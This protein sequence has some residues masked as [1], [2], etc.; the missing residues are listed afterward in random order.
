MDLEKLRASR[1]LAGC[2][3]HRIESLNMADLQHAAVS[4]RPVDQL[5]SFF[6]I[7]SDWL[8]NENIDAVVEQ[9]N[10][11]S[12]V[13]DSGNG[14]SRSIHFAQ[15]FTIIRKRRGLVQR[16]NFLGAGP[17]YVDNTGKLDVR[18]LGVEP[19]VLLSDI[20]NTDDGDLHL[21]HRD[22][23]NSRGIRLAYQFLPIDHQRFSGLDRQRRDLQTLHQPDS[24][25]TDNRNIEAQV[26]VGFC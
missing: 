9:I 11:N 4:P 7:R 25:G 12:A 19:R 23:C 14:Q 24:R 13:I 22:D 10:T 26:L 20:P 17:E 21:L 5:S 6:E 18:K 8:L 1:G 15:D 2:R 3:N 16:C